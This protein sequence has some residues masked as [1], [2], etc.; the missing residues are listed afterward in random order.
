MS[1]TLYLYQ[2]DE[3]KEKLCLLCEIIW[4]NNFY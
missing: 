1:V 3:A 4:I 2:Q